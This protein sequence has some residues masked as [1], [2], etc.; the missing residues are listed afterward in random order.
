VSDI[1]IGKPGR[2]DVSRYEPSQERDTILRI[3]EAGQ[4]PEV[5]IKETS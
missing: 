5:I 4:P 2:V 3:L 1:Y